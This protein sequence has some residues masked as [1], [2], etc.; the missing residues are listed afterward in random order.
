MAYKIVIISHWSVKKVR[1][2]CKELRKNHN[3]VP[4]YSVCIVLCAPGRLSTAC[5][6]GRSWSLEP[7]PWMATGCKTSACFH[8]RTPPDLDFDADNVDHHMHEKLMGEQP[9]SHW[10]WLGAN[11]R[12]LN[13]CSNFQVLTSDLMFSPE[14]SEVGRN[15]LVPF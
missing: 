8:L 9:S 2:L 15:D 5:N 11:V 6:V 4:F 13:R 10:P 1:K 12:L 7:H 14:F 3:K